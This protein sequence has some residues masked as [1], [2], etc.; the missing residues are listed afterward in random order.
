MALH[1]TITADNRLLIKS[2]EDSQNAV[3]SAMKNIEDS[4]IGVEEFV[5]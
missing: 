3:K 2:L 1:Y 5:P 4:G